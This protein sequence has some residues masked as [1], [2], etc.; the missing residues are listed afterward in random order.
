MHVFNPQGS[1]NKTEWRIAGEVKAVTEQLECLVTVVLI[2]DVT[3]GNVSQTCPFRYAPPGIYMAL[4]FR[5]TST[6]IQSGALHHANSWA[7][8]LHFYFDITSTCKLM[9]HHIE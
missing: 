1:M 8:G 6:N 3:I 2:D 5:K 9:I 7:V 4:V